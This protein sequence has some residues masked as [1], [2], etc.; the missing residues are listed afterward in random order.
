MNAVE[1]VIHYATEIDTEAP[2]EL[3]ASKPDISWPAEGQVELNRVFLSYRPEL[4]AVLK[5]KSGMCLQ[6]SSKFWAGI[7]MSNAGGEK[8]GIV[9]RYVLELSRLVGPN[10]S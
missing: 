7:T 6:E 1:R 3:P 8:I 9:G 10:P 2:H 5:G 4:P